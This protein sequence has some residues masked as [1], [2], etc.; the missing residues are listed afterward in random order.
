MQ[1]LAMEL[2]QLQQQG[3]SVGA[4]VVQWLESNTHE[5]WDIGITATQ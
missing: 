1:C 4:R 3:S 5:D 2:G